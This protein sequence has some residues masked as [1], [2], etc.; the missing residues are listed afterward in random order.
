M[1]DNVHKQPTN[2]TQMRKLWSPP[3]LIITAPIMSPDNSCI[4]PA[5]SV[6]VP[7]LLPVDDTPLIIQLATVNP[8][9]SP[10]IRRGIDINRGPE[11]P[12]K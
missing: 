8:L 9:P 2:T 12:L 11:C 7:E 10:N 1:Q 5:I 3:K 4:A 6:A